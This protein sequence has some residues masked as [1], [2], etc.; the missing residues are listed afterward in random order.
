[1]QRHID[2]KHRNFICKVCS[3]SYKQRSNLLTHLRLHFE[4]FICQYCGLEIRRLQQFRKHVYQFH[5]PHNIDLILSI[6]LH[7]SYSCRFCI[8]TFPS[9]VYRNCHEH[10]VHKGRKEDAFKCKECNLIFLTKENLRSHSFE[11][12]SGNL[13]FCAFPDCDRF[14][15]NVKRLKSH[16]LIHGP[17]SFECEVSS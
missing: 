13:H 16:E 11:H 5:E 14:F 7:E 12:Y 10:S 9:A 4:K 6:Q 15:K 17:A 8:R 1:M 3:N 2:S